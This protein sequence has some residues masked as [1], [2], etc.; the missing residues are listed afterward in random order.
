MY[1][2]H[3]NKHRPTSI[4]LS[5]TLYMYRLDLDL[6]APARDAFQDDV[7]PYIYTILSCREDG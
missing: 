3:V 2:S 7:G 4:Y 6:Y 5:K 1:T